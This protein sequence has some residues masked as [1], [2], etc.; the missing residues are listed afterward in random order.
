LDADRVIEVWAEGAYGSGYLVAPHLVL[1]ALHVVADGVPTFADGSAAVF[2]DVELRPV[3]RIRFLSTKRW[4]DCRVAWPRAGTARWDAALLEIIDP[5]WT[6]VPGTV[7]WGR[8]TSTAPNVECEVIGFPWAQRSTGGVREVEHVTG[9][10]SPVTGSK[11]GHLQVE[12]P[13]GPEGTAQPWAG[14]SGAAVLCEGLVTA[15]V[16]ED[17]LHWRDQRLVALPMYRLFED[18]GFRAALREHTGTEEPVLESIELAPLLS[19]PAPPDGSWRAEISLASLLRADAEAVRFRGRSG[20]LEKLLA[21]CESRG[22]AARL[23]TGPGGQGKTRL[24]RELMA[25]L[26][27]R[28]WVTGLVD[29]DVDVAAVRARLLRLRTATFLTVDYAETRLQQIKDLINALVHYRGEAPLRLMLIARSAGDWWNDLAQ[30]S[31]HTTR[32]LILNAAV[33]V[34]SPLEKSSTGRAA[35]FAEA[36]TDLSSKLRE[37]KPDWHPPPAI[38]AARL[39]FTAHRYDTALSL[40]MEAMAYLLKPDRIGGE[41]SAADII[42]EHEEPYWASAASS[43]HINLHPRTQR[44]VVAAASLCG[45][46]TEAEAV[47]F[48]SRV[49]GV[50]DR[51]E[52][53][54]L[55]IA[56]WFRDLYP[57][58]RTYGSL[59]PTEDVRVETAFWGGLEPDR[60]AEHLITMVVRN[61][62]ALLPKLLRN[63]PTH[64]T[65]RALITL[66]RAS[67]YEPEIATRLEELLANVPEMATVAIQTA[68]QSEY[69]QPLVEAV[70]LLVDRTT[71]DE[72]GLA[73]FAELSNALPRQTRLFSSVALTIAQILADVRRALAETDPDTYLADLAQ[74]LNTLANRLAGAGHLE[75][76][77][78]TAQEAVDIRRRLI[79]TDREEHLPALAQSLVTLADRAIGV[80]RSEEGRRIAEEA[81]RHL[82]ELAAN[83]PGVHRPDLAEALN[84]LAMALAVDGR[85]TQAL[86]HVKTA[87]AIRQELWQTKPRAYSPDLAR[88]LDTM[89]MQL[90]AMGRRTEAQHTAERSVALFRALADIDSDAY[91]AELATALS[92][93]TRS[94]L[95][96]GRAEDA[97]E[98]ARETV[99]LRRRLAET[100]P[101]AF[102]AALA[103]SLSTLADLLAV[104]GWPRGARKLATESVRRCRDLAAANA[105]CKPLLAQALTVH[106]HVVIRTGQA[107]Q[108][109]AMGL[110]KE[111]Y[112]LY[113]ATAAS[114]ASAMHCASMLAYILHRGA[115]PGETIIPLLDALDSRQMIPDRAEA[116]LAAT[117]AELRRIA[118][119]AVEQTLT[120]LENPDAQ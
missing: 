12:V 68:A 46:R 81:V 28:G 65:H 37:I 19:A 108:E 59:A 55:R 47:T 18:G 3:V 113:R 94:Q 50:T 44:R 24:A 86:E 117:T 89:T 27:G 60:L 118:T 111:A 104:T 69:P 101:T 1:T 15:M 49:P 98:T 93:L 39:N 99:G 33:D 74:S 43:Q 63:A 17:T 48:L 119:P 120:T 82:R 23:L 97:A 13:L 116:L 102:S 30:Q 31:D 42:L 91:M 95:G 20:E 57:L 26:Q 115:V 109:A 61:D 106:L 2:E 103:D 11:T 75:E 16:I 4:M 83:K 114:R 110:A 67:V 35:A 58:T 76:A 64:Q 105:N 53:S 41:D 87:V 9:W 88:S 38:P 66:S 72:R 25:K 84:T 32:S 107:Q 56:C 85:H 112:D 96:L 92:N 5:Q 90:T 29:P 70:R 45:A 54:R 71:P 78:A 14:V 77:L 40:Q 80:G 8:P 10:I 7:R 51:D 100:N 52:D 62:D 79:L 22:F 6:P 34:L 21:W 36:I 73:L